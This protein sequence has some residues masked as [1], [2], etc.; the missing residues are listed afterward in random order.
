M[1]LPEPSPA[2]AATIHRPLA[3]IAARLFSA[4]FLTAMFACV[5][6]ASSRGVHVLESVFYRQAMGVLLMVPVAL[7]GPGLAALKTRRP[8]THASRMIVGMV[9]MTLNFLSFALLPIAEATAIGF[10]VPIVA[11]LLSIF[12]LSE[13]VGVHRW[14]AIAVGLIGVLV[15]I[16]PGN[17]HIPP[18]GALVAMCGVAM[19]AWVSILIR[20][21]GATESP[22]T[23]MF[24]FSV[25]SMVPLGLAML[26]VGQAHDAQTWGII[27]LMGLFGAAAQLGITW[28]LR[29]APVSVVLPMDYSSLIWAALLG[30]LIW[31]NW[32]VPA[33]WIGAPLIIGSGLYIAWRE[34][35]LAR[36]RK[37]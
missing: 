22:V 20:K 8:W 13:S 11:T 10:M 1:A 33:T 37:A 7:A 21:L 19:T 23:T 6:L 35:R 12:L 5:K 18:A 14:G 2:S 30:W 3:G 24:W 16:Q 32:P 36:L 9:A 15:V 17:G 27:G 25:S 26:F 31:Q 4:V 34:N 28:S 29:L